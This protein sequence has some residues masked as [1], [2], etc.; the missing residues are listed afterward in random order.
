MKVEEV[1]MFETKT[2]LS[3]LV[4]RVRREGVTYRIT[5]RG[6]PVAELKPIR[7][8]RKPR[9]KRGYG[10]GSLIY[11]AADFGEP[12]AD[13]EDYMRKDEASRRRTRSGLAQSR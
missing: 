2:H 5:K 11:M 7:P 8:P 6:T 10:K 4:E 1:G 12:L 9:L 13:F 3:E